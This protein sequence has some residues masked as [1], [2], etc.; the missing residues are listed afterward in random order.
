MAI[1]Y[2]DTGSINILEISSS[3]LVSG[4]LTVSGNINTTR[5]L[6]GSLLGTAS[7]ASTASYVL[8]GSSTIIIQ[9]ESISQGSAGTINFSGSGVEA[10]VAGGIATV[11]IPGGS[12]NAFPYTG[13]AQITGSLGVTGSISVLGTGSNILVVSGS[14][15]AILQINE[16]S[17][18]G[19]LFTVSSAS[20]DILNIFDTK[21]VT[22]SGSL[23][24]TGSITGTDGLYV[25]SLTIQGGVTNTITGSLII[26]GSSTTDLIIRG[27]TI[28]TGS[29]TVS[30]SAA[31]ELDV[32]GSTNIL[33][34]TTITGSLVVSG[35]GGSGVFSK[36]G[37]IAD[38]TN[39]VSTSG[40]YIVWRAPFSCSVVA[41]Y[42]RRSGGGNAQ[43]NARR[44]GSAGYALH[45]GS[46]LTL[47]VDNTWTQSNTVVTQSYVP[48]DSLEIVISGSGNSQVAVQVD[49]IKVI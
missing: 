39:G 35:S 36:G 9:D 7:Y 5:G 22:I 12:G 1:F 16:T 11:I 40:S 48:G 49:F 25:N 8:G 28:M 27:D 17:S 45:T 33:G 21:L 42:G 47:T 44:S 19:E 41:L 32:R 38:I 14:K 46:N 6:T 18:I 30:G 23:E 20:V 29:L 26:S 13:S 4:T 15:G 2:T 43:V 31:T 37:T 34:N 24:V 10:A 3:L